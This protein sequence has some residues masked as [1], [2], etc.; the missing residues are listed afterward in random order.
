MTAATPAQNPAAR[1]DDPLIY[2]PSMEEILASIR[3]IIADDQSLPDAPKA[4]SVETRGTGSDTPQV[5]SAP[6]PVHVLHSEPFR[7]SDESASSVPP[8]AEVT[9][10]AE[11]MPHRPMEA[12]EMSSL[13]P[14]TVA[15]EPTRLQ[16][17]EAGPSRPLSSMHGAITPQFAMPD[18][19]PPGRNGG[20]ATMRAS[21]AG[22]GP[23]LRSSAELVTAKREPEVQV[24][25]TELRGQTA[26]ARTASDVDPGAPLQRVSNMPPNGAAPAPAGARR[27]PAQAGGLVSSATDQSV[28]AAFNVLAAT[29]LADNS[30][31]LLALAREMIRPMLRAW[32]D[33]NLP[34]MVERMVRAEIERVARGG[35]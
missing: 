22:S 14:E 2:E 34:P 4:G 25:D 31:E 3:R 6:A 12:P 35:R 5:E 24:P 13:I 7:D 1:G 20:P 29:R 9:E 18:S 26:P 21:M 27:A 23:A 32:L 16:A 30:E 11:R 8:T 10:V 19:P 33:D 28:V 17:Q 15:R